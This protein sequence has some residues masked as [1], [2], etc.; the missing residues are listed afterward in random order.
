MVLDDVMISNDMIMPNNVNI[1][2]FMM[3]PNDMIIQ[4]T[5]INDYSKSQSLWWNRWNIK[6]WLSSP[7]KLCGIIEKNMFRGAPR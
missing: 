1:P 7:M 6:G 4:N 5:M 3:M 2:K